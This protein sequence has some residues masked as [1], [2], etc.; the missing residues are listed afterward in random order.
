MCA[1]KKQLGP[2]A[3]LTKSK[4]VFEANYEHTFVPGYAKIAAPIILQRKEEKF[5]WSDEWK[6]SFI[7]LKD[8]VTN[9]LTS[10]SVLTQPN[11]EKKFTLVADASGERLGAVFEQEGRRD[12][13]ASR[14]L[15]GDEKNSGNKMGD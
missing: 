5:I 9:K 12:V 3:R 4:I 15:I 7:E 2:D 6:R 13:H 8:K 14:A 10:P 1:L 11:F